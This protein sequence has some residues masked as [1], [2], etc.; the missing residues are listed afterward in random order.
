MCRDPHSRRLKIHSLSFA[1]PNARVIRTRFDVP[2][3]PH[4]GVDTFRIMALLKTLPSNIEGVDATYHRIDDVQI[5]K[6]RRN[7]RIEV[8]GFM[9]ESTKD[10]FD[11]GTAEGRAEI[12][13]Q[14]WQVRG[15]LFQELYTRVVVNQEPIFTVAYE[16]VKTQP[17]PNRVTDADGNPI[18]IFADATSDHTD[19]VA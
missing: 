10:A 18:S 12:L 15:D 3:L 4:D 2:V 8:T 17:G 11:N 13:R 9:N 7:A 19:N 5:S 16:V 1:V 6:G 14:T